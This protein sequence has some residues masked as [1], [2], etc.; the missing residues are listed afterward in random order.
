VGCGLP[1]LLAK[2]TILPGGVGVVEGAM[3]ALYCSL[4]VPEAVN[5][6]VILAYRVLS[7]WLPRLLGFP[8][9]RYFQHVG[10]VGQV[11]RPLHNLF[12][13]VV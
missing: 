8:L 5:V 10:N 12:P 11:S 4:G 6:V 3:A 13:L 9:V 1:D 7:F 2:L